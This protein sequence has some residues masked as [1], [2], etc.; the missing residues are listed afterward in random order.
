MVLF[1]QYNPKY[2]KKKKEVD[3]ATPI[4]EMYRFK[5]EDGVWK[6]EL[7]AEKMSTK[8]ES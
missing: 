3:L 5:L 1:L 2:L 6:T 8:S 4:K 7:Y